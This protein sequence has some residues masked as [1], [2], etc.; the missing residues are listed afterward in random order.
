MFWPQVTFQGTANWSTSNDAG[1]VEAAFLTE[2]G[3][4]TG[5]FYSQNSQMPSGGTAGILRGTN[6]AALDTPADAQYVRLR[7]GVKTSGAT[8]AALVFR[9][10]EIKMVQSVETALIRTPADASTSNVLYLTVDGEANLRR[11]DGYNLSYI[12]PS[13]ALVPLTWILVNIVTASTEFMQLSDNA[14]NMGTPKYRMPW[15]GQIVG[16]TWRINGDILAGGATDALSVVVHINSTAIW[17]PVTIG[18]NTTGA[19]GANGYV[20]IKRDGSNSSRVFEA[21][22]LMGVQITTTG[23]YSPTTLDMTCILWLAMDYKEIAVSVTS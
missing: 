7:V 1:F 20:T 16:L 14:G 10:Y 18:S 15:G 13:T 23:T 8:R 2:G 19:G 21:G 5:S 22:D 4:V 11:S 3:A 9:V 6:L 12:I 17:T